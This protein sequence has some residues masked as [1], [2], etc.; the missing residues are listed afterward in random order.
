MYDTIE[1]TAALE[2]SLMLLTK[3]ASSFNSPPSYPP[4]PPASHNSHGGPYPSPHDNIPDKSLPKLM[5]IGLDSV[6]DEYIGRSSHT[7]GSYHSDYGR[8]IGLD[9]GASNSRVRDSPG[10]YNDAAYDGKAMRGSHPF[11]ESRHNGGGGWAS[12]QDSRFRNMECA[13]DDLMRYGG[14]SGDGSSYR[15]MF[16]SDVDRFDNIPRSHDHDASFHEHGPMS[17]DQGLQHSISRPISHD[18]N[19]SL[20]RNREHMETSFD[21]YDYPPVPFKHHGPHTNYQDPEAS[22]PH[23]YSS[24]STVDPPLRKR[25]SSEKYKSS[26]SSSKRRRSHGEKKPRSRPHHYHH[27]RADSIKQEHISPP[28]PPKPHMIDRLGP[29]LSQSEPEDSLNLSGGEVS[30]TQRLGPATIEA[31]LGPALSGQN[32]PSLP[33]LREKLNERKKTVSPLFPSPSADISSQHVFPP[34]P[35]NTPPPSDF[36]SLSPSLPLFPPPPDD[37]LLSDIEMLKSTDAR[38]SMVQRSSVITPPMVVSHPSDRSDSGRSSKS[39]SS[40]VG[41]NQSK[42]RLFSSVRSRLST[43]ESRQRSVSSTSL[44]LRTRT[45]SSRKSGKKEIETVKEANTDLKIT[46]V[47]PKAQ[48]AVTPE[49]PREPKLKNKTDSVASSVCTSL[50]AATPFSHSN[51]PPPPLPVSMLGY[52]ASVVK[53]I[54]SSETR[55]SLPFATFGSESEDSDHGLVIDED[56]RIRSSP[57]PLPETRELEPPSCPAL[58]DSMGK[59]DAVSIYSSILGPTLIRQL[60]APTGINLLQRLYDSI[61]VIQRLLTRQCTGQLQL[62][63]RIRALF[64]SYSISSANLL[65]KAKDL[66]KTELLHLKKKCGDNVS[67]WQEKIRRFNLLASKLPQSEAGENSYGDPTSCD[68]MGGQDAISLKLAPLLDDKEEGEISDDSMPL[69][70]QRDLRPL[71]PSLPPPPPPPPPPPSLPPP[72]PPPSLPPP[73]LPPPPPPPLKVRADSTDDKLSSSISLGIAAASAMML[74]TGQSSNVVAKPIEGAEKQPLNPAHVKVAHLL[75]E[76]I[77]SLS[78]RKGKSTTNKVTSR[79]TALDSSAGHN[80]T[81]SDSGAGHNTT[82]SGSGAGHNTTGSGSMVGHDTTGSGSGAVH[83]RSASRVGRNATG[84]DSGVGHQDAVDCIGLDSQTSMEEGLSPTAADDDDGSSGECSMSVCSTLSNSLMIDEGPAS[85]SDL[86]HASMKGYICQKRRLP[87]L[88]SGELTPSPLSLSSGELTPSPP[89]SPKKVRQQSNLATIG[90]GQPGGGSVGGGG[91]HLPSSRPEPPVVGS[92]AGGGGGSHLPS[93]RP[94]PPVGGNV[95]GGG[96]HLPSSRPEP[97]GGRG[98]T[99]AWRDLKHH[100]SKRKHTATQP[101]LRNTSRSR[102]RSRSPRNKQLSSGTYHPHGGRSRKRSLSRSRERYKHLK[103]SRSPL[104]LQR[105]RSRSPGARGGWDYGA[106]RKGSPHAGKSR[107][108]KGRVLDDDEDLEL[109]QLKKQVILSIVHKPDQQDPAT[110]ELKDDGVPSSRGKDQTKED[111]PHEDVSKSEAV[112]K[113]GI[114]SKSKAVSKSEEI[115]KS[116]ALPPISSKSNDPLLVSTGLPAGK[117]GPK[118]LEAFRDKKLANIPNNLVLSLMSTKTIPE[119]LKSSHSSNSSRAGSN[120]NSP[121]RSPVHSNSSSTVSLQKKDL[122]KSRSSLAVKKSSVSVKVR[123]HLR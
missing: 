111:M 29:S 13:P 39:S 92:V 89:L 1:T 16:D 45:S 116:K 18:Q 70:I 8:D 110:P 27:S 113:S 60:S 106:R 10:S 23:R 71:P 56:A 84:K 68:G 119:S 75:Q 57:A 81:G 114:V 83:A 120:C 34:P 100:T 12:E 48:S 36:P 61:I 59:E 96:S 102:N 19:A 90:K 46:P 11:G 30:I 73:S 9:S 123:I 91:S 118:K 77:T 55:M 50:D 44:G 7:E 69:L 105:H 32:D 51:P 99:N 33:D 117:V 108:K 87:S 67:K 37:N 76:I 98:N 54:L 82:G 112:S 20:P 3:L 104:L 86:E 26:Y 64:N 88:S 72:P 80:T 79:D 52:S 95:G 35:S 25:H 6:R 101:R 31:R 97:P 40:T 21:E 74:Q 122:A 5:N 85:G 62:I 14:G 109:L 2:A 93:S 94:E 15:E 121:A 22:L 17:H 63:S 43:K 24:S 107:D 4:P 41:G 38:V 65:G 28:P 66:Y 103:R 49:L 53:N 78:S 47:L 42:T 115:P 58:K